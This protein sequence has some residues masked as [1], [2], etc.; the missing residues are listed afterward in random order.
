MRS[1]SSARP[2]LIFAW[3]PNPYQRPGR[4]TDRLPTPPSISTRVEHRPKF[5]RDPVRLSNSTRAPNPRTAHRH[6]QHSPPYQ[7]SRLHLCL[8]SSSTMERQLDCCPIQKARP[9]AP[10]HRRLAHRPTAVG[11]CTPHLDPISPSC[12]TPS[13]LLLHHHREQPGQT[14]S[15]STT[16]E[17]RW[18]RLSCSIR[19]KSYEHS[20]PTPTPPVVSRL[21]TASSFPTDSFLWFRQIRLPPPLL[22]PL[23]TTA[24]M[25]STKWSNGHPAIVP[26]GSS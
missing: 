21:S 22:S 6:L 14:G 25:R 18:A 17:G 7:R 24:D 26:S 8:G 1:S 10:P 11:L 3:T 19:R 9:N 20:Q 16:A 15:V 12:D 2:L 13:M 5:T 23:S 4:E